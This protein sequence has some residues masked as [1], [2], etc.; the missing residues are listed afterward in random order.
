MA[1]P[2]GS[3]ALP[4][5]LQIPACGELPSEGLY[6]CSRWLPLIYVKGAFEAADTYQ[7]HLCSGPRT[8]LVAVNREW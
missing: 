8:G 5:V 3:L 2:E 4:G 1:L 7:H 6:A